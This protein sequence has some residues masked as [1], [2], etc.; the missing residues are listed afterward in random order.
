MQPVSVPQVMPADSSVWKAR[1]TLQICPCSEIS[2]LQM[3]K[4]QCLKTKPKGSLQKL[5]DMRHICSMAFTWISCTGSQCL[6]TGSRLNTGRHPLLI[7]YACTVQL[8][9]EAC[10]QNACSL[11]S[12]TSTFYRVKQR[13][14]Q[15]IDCRP[16]KLD[17]TLI[18][19]LLNLLS[20]YG[21]CYTVVP[22]LKDHP[23]VHLKSS[24]KMDGFSWWG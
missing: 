4:R 20:L 22:L 8:L 19:G 6:Q 10:Q 12:H 2:T 24:P 7:G 17:C 16:V 5:R 3:C 11:Y 13:I 9:N 21:Y 14:Q 18:V 23:K 15:V 1:T